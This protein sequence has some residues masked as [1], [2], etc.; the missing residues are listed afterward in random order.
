MYQRR[1]GVEDGDELLR[2]QEPR[3]DSLLWD[4]GGSGLFCPFD[5]MVVL[6]CILQELPVS[7]VML[8]AS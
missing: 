5:F 3:A 2:L 8:A 4:S 7:L 1:A 6:F